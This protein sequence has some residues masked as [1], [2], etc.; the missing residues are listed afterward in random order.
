M[1]TAAAAKPAP[2]IAEAILTVT[3][4]AKA[5]ASRVKIETKS[6]TRQM[7]TAPAARPG[8]APAVTVEEAPSEIE[9][10]APFEIE[11]P[12]P[13]DVDVPFEIEAPTPLDVD[14]PFEIEAP[15]PL[16]IDEPF[17]YQPIEVISLPALQA[18]GTTSKKTNFT[19]KM[20]T[21]Q[22]VSPSTI[23]FVAKVGVVQRS[24]I[25]VAAGP[26]GSQF[27]SSQSKSPTTLAK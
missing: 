2:V 24:S 8:A 19:V 23:N 27:A 12:T 3:P 4:T 15:A 16:G 20:A 18:Q 14:V 26:A 11:A 1:H 25:D 9:V 21:P 13:L 5:S 10:V 6:V 22:K 17:A 7:H